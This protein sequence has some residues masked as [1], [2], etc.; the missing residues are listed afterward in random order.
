LVKT[1][2]RGAD[3]LG[4]L[5]ETEETSTYQSPGLALVLRAA[6]AWFCLTMV[7]LL[8]LGPRDRAGDGSGA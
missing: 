8:L 2:P 5:T 7:A 1:G 3:G 6:G 4:V